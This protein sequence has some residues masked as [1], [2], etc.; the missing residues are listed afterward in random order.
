MLILRAVLGLDE[1]GG[2][3]SP[4]KTQDLKSRFAGP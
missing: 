3:P 2:I 4:L 1:E